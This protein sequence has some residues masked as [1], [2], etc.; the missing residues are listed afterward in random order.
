[1][2]CP[3]YRTSFYLFSEI[4]H[5]IHSLKTSCSV[6]SESHV[7]GA[8]LGGHYVSVP[9]LWHLPKSA[10]ALPILYVVSFRRPEAIFD[11][12]LSLPTTEH[13]FQGW[14]LDKSQ[15]N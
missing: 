2:L 8:V 3:L 13:S 5:P 6:P 4:S 10:L 12:S 11:S 15:S 7:S 9:I 1:M 14:T